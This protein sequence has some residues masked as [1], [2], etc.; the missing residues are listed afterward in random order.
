MIIVDTPVESYQIKGQEIWVKR[1]DLSCES[2]GPPFAKVRGLYLVL[3]KLKENGIKTVGYMET[4]ISMAG[5][6]ISFFC[7]R[8]GMKAVIFMPNY[9]DGLR[10]NQELQVSKWKEFGAD[11]I[12]INKP[13]R[14]SINFY[15]ARNILLDKYTSSVMLPQG[16]PFEETVQEV[17]KQA[18]SVVPNFKSVIS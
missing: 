16:M 18:S 13:N 10:H 12:H 11:I 1:E 15:K 5:W 9:K 4:S 2:P 8:L 17:C 14:M 7:K 6:G 3:K